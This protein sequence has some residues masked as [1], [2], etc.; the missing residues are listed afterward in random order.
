M[1]KII[2][3]LLAVAMLACTLTACGGDAAAAKEA[4]A[5]GGVRF[6]NMA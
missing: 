4:R 3:V 1:K 6:A 2:T 5:T